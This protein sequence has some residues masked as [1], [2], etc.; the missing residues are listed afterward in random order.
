MGSDVHKALLVEDGLHEIARIGLAVSQA[1]TLQ[2]MAD[3]LVRA[4]LDSED[5][6]LCNIFFRGEDGVFRMS[7]SA[8]CDGLDAEQLISECPDFRPGEGLVGWVAGTGR[9]GV[10]ADVDRDERWVGSEWAR[11]VGIASA[12]AFPIQREG[13]VSGVFIVL[14]LEKNHFE[15]ESLKSFDILAGYASTAMEKLL[16]IEEIDKRA[17]RFAVLNELTGYIA[18][19]LNLSDV[20]ERITKAVNELLSGNSSRIYLKEKGTDSY[21]LCATGGLNPSADRPFY[22]KPGMGI[23]GRMVEKGA[24]I[25]L[26]DLY[27]E[28]DFLTPEWIRAHDIHS[29]IGCPLTQDEEVVGALV[30]LAKKPNH[31]DHEDLEFL[32]ALAAQAVAAIENANLHEAAGAR[33]SEL[34]SLQEAARELTSQ[35]QLPDL[36]ERIAT[37][38]G[39]LLGADRCLI[40]NQVPE[41]AGTPVF[42]NRGLSE[43]YVELLKENLD[44]IIASRAIEDGRMVFIPNL[45]ESKEYSLPAETVQKEGIASLL[46]L[47]LIHK[48]EGFG[49][50]NFYWDTPQT[51]SDSQR[52]L[53][54][55]FAD[56]VALAIQNARLHEADRERIA[57]LEVFQKVTKNLTSEYAIPE[58]MESIDAGSVAILGA[59]RCLLI[60]ED[61]S[62]QKSRIWYSRGISQRH[63]NWLRRN[64]SK[65]LSRDVLE[66]PRIVPVSNAWHDERYPFDPA[67][68]RREGF[69]G[70]LICPLMDG[71]RAF[72]VLNFFWESARTFTE[73]ELAL[74]QAF[75]D[76][77]AVAIKKARLFEEERR[78]RNF[79]DSVL[80]EMGDPVMITDEKQRIIYW[81]S[82]AE[83][84]YGY[85]KDEVIGNH[86]SLMVSKDEWEVANRHSC[87]VRKNRKPRT[88]DVHTMTKEKIKVPVSVTLSPVKLDGKVIAVAEIHKDLTD[89]IRAEQVLQESEGRFRR[90]FEASNDAIIVIDPWR[91]EIVD[92]NPNTCRMLEYA[93]EELIGSR[94]SSIHPTDMPQ[95][96]RFARMVYEK[97]AGWLDR[98]T[99]RTKSGKE[100]PAETSASLIEISGRTLM[101]LLVRDITER[102]E[103]EEK[104][105][106]R[107]KIEALGQMSAGVAHDFNNVLSIILGRTQLIQETAEAPEMLRMLKIIEKAAMS[108]AQTV[109]R[110]RDFARKRERRPGDRVD[111]NDVVRDVVEMTRPRWKNECE[112]AG[113]KI[114]MEVA[115]GA[116]RPVVLAEAG[117]VQ[118]ALINLINNSIDAMPGGGHLSISTGAV[119]EGFS[120]SVQD[121]GKGM[122][123]EMCE[124][125]FEPFFTTKGDHGTGL[126]LS[127]V[128][129]ILEQHGGSVELE[130]VPGEGTTVRLLFPASGAAAHG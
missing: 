18:K 105:R 54:Q 83:N 27:N 87:F 50:L 104:L 34:E 92:V 65:T 15:A 69:R 101:I 125:V 91:D 30:C 82:A 48:G 13:A 11:S 100:I 89:R 80:G 75:A 6:D 49:A 79:L 118:E 12:A 114:E 73:D 61:A 59:D 121:S 10:T 9:P 40:L 7:A 117:E 53:A 106:H 90:I 16:L 78:S 25:I 74:A 60:S 122:T 22:F 115:A 86:I 67:A 44:R 43:G 17:K 130:S 56:H 124:K 111:L 66:N 110:L 97:G 112:R 38:G 64:F 36:L 32:E 31:F 28:P 47:P 108:G 26:G 23:T 126:G 57:A 68:A 62:S 119:P 88:F 51:L 39:R 99:C 24:P 3:A 94:L 128:Y 58:L 29:Y 21:Q 8:A 41:N 4:G 42:F 71:E 70:M 45:L 109:R 2:E 52:S 107:E 129:R 120:I 72:G 123:P 113:Q 55:T 84:L 98:I 1:K 33:I 95:L 81:N 19:N 63:Q 93:P 85:A 5:I 103:M 77:A 127:M 35:R 102:L 20:L 76:Q 116:E 14:S 46:A 37:E 96:L